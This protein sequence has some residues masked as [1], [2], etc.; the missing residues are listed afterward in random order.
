MESGPFFDDE[1]KN[2]EVL[3]RVARRLKPGIGWAALMRMHFFVVALLTVL[4]A[5]GA[6]PSVQYVRVQEGVNLEVLNWGGSGQDLV[7]LAGLG[8]TARDFNDFA[9][10]LV[11]KYHVY[12][13]TRRGYGQ[14]SIPA[15]TAEN[16]SPKRLGDDV[17][18]V[19]DY[20]NLRRPVLVGHSIAGEELSSIG[21]RYPEKVAGLIY[22]DAAGP[23]AFYD[24]SKWRL[25][26][27][28][29]RFRAKIGA[30]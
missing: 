1:F 8:G 16:Y 12:G 18:A 19:C 3:E 10:K 13:I 24:A 17:L 11:G 9:Q 30:A 4:N 25:H 20:L 15:V 29:V 14:S 2:I 6:E 23:Y 21:T 28:P 22:L 27:G 26:A 7:L 5:Q